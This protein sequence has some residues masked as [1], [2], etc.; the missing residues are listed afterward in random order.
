MIWSG[1]TNGLFS[2]RSGYHLVKEML[3]VTVVGSSNG[4]HNSD[5]WN[6]I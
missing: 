6:T 5:I 1:T 3:E 4:F 2:V